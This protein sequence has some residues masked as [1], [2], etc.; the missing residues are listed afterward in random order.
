MKRGSGAYAARVLFA[1]VGLVFLLAG[2]KHKD[3]D[4]IAVTSEG[5]RL[6][7]E[8]ID[9]DPIALLP[10]GPVVLGWTNVQAFFASSFGNEANRLAAKYVPLGQE[11]GFVPQRD[12][13]T[14]V[15]GVYS[16]AGADAVAVAQGDFNADLIRAAADRR[17]M[18]PLGVPLVHSK[19][20]G[21][22]VY[23]AGN[24]GF[25]VVTNHTMLVGNETGMRRA[26]DRIRD[27]RVGREVPEWMTKLIENPQASMVFAGDLTNQPHVA[28]MAKTAPF[29]NGLMNFRVLGNFQPPG[30]NLAGTLTYPDATSASAGAD[31]LRGIGQ[32]AGAMNVLAV[33]GFGSPIQ[34]LQVK[35]QEADATF[36]MAVEGQGLVRLLA[37]L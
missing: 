22:D 23:T 25:T 30:V 4:S 16:L 31:A 26:L 19:Y 27:G 18:T 34:N 8:A 6:S 29:L 10:P 14:L 17:S 2:C 20:A 7:S 28:A 1:L 21:N 36:V 11:A 13:R 32:M 37:L 33:F 35:T 3:G 24:V 5:T 15:G 12:L 9:R